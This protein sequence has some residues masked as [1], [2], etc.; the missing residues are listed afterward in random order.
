MAPISKTALLSLLLASGALAAPTREKKGIRAPAHRWIP[1][2]AI[3]SRQTG[4]VEAANDGGGW[5]MPVL[6][7]GQQVTLN[8]DTGSSDLYAP[9]PISGLD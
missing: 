5:I 1:K 7:G 4:A 3:V 2:K 8:I 6:I 9:R